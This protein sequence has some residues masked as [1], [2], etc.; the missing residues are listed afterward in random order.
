MYSFIK[1]DN[2]IGIVF[3]ADI[4]RIPEWKRSEMM[5]DDIMRRLS[6][7]PSI[8]EQQSGKEVFKKLYEDPLLLIVKGKNNEETLGFIG[9]N[10]LLTSIESWSQNVEST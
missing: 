4:K 1:E 7:F 5:I 3:N 6:E 9:K 2:I 8:D 10:E